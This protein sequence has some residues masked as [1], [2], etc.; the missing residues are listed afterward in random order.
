M[1]TVLFENKLFTALPLNSKATSSKMKNMVVTP[2][3][4]SEFSSHGYYGN[5]HYADGYY[6]YSIYSDGFYG[7]SHNAIGFHGYSHLTVTTV[8]VTATL[9]T[10]KQCLSP[11]F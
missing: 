3:L 5:K 4:Y 11:P 7:N 2:V 10:S 6:G 8:M 1:N 9:A